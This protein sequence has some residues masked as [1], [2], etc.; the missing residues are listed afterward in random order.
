MCRQ[1]FHFSKVC[2][3]HERYLKH[4]GMWNVGKMFERRGECGEVRDTAFFAGVFKKVGRRWAEIPLTVRAQPYPKQENP[5]VCL[6]S[7]VKAQSTLTPLRAVNSQRCA[8]VTSWAFV[9]I[10]GPAEAPSALCSHPSAKASSGS[11]SFNPLRFHKALAW[12]GRCAN[13]SLIAPRGQMATCS[14]R[15]WC[16]PVTC[17]VPTHTGGASAKI[18]FCTPTHTIHVPPQVSSSRLKTLSSQP[19]WK[20]NR[21]MLPPLLVQGWA[22]RFSQKPSVAS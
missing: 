6:S 1:K 10:T 7:E 4:H 8:H 15:P 19:E 12:L 2:L 16:P 17:A 3:K 14:P 13:S 9:H 22:G 11:V 21:A 18:G 20:Q 5:N